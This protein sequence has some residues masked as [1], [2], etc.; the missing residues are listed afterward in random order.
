MGLAGFRLAAG[1]MLV[2]MATVVAAPCNA[3]TSIWRYD[4][5]NKFQKAD[6]AAKGEVGAGSN[7]PAAQQNDGDQA[8]AAA[9]RD[10]VVAD[11]PEEFEA[12]ARGLELE[13]LERV[14]LAGLDIELWWLRA[15]P[16][17]AVESAIAELRER[18]PRLIIDV[19]H[20][21]DPGTGKSA[22]KPSGNLPPSVVRRLFGWDAS[23]AAC[24]EG[25]RIG[26]IDT[27][28]DV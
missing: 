16:S 23:S 22:T 19:N 5:G 4:K 7:A 12:A 28:V 24:G 9:A 8:E 25:I 27:P 13:I 14:P 6:D 17:L 2:A 10:I 21:F 20:R 18:F 3:E 11:P 15:P 1:V 26:M